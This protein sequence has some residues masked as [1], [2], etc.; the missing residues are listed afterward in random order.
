M[1]NHAQSQDRFLRREL[2]P[3]A[4][5]RLHAFVFQFGQAIQYDVEISQHE[6]EEHTP[7]EV[8]EP[9][10]GH[11]RD[12]QVEQLAGEPFRLATLLED[13]PVQQFV[14]RAAFAS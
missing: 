7:H 10:E 4:I 12:R 8:T 2:G 14:Q 1:A 3:P 9:R 13:P 6:P 5:D 11:Q